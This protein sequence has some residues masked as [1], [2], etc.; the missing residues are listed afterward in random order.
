MRLPWPMITP[1]FD[2]MN[3]RNPQ[4]IGIIEGYIGGF[5]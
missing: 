5:D 3:E 1:H 4:A 2:R